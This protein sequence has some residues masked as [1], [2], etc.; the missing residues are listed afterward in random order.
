MA[1]AKKH[2]SKRQAIISGAYVIKR[3]PGGG[4]PVI[5]KRPVDAK[6][7]RAVSAAPKECRGWATI[8]WNDMDAGQRREI[9]GANAPAGMFVGAP[10]RPDLIDPT[11]TASG[12]RSAMERE[13]G[14]SVEHSECYLECQ[15]RDR[16]RKEASQAANDRRR[17][18]INDVARAAAIARD[19][20]RAARRKAKNAES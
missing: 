10:Y 7:N 12:L 18:R 2:K 5:R 8:G 3:G 13:L 9:A 4:D 17:A 19:L 15:A 6:A 20:E 1:Q 14:E 16:A 11:A